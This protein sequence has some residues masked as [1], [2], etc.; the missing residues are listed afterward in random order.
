MTTRRAPVTNTNTVSAGVNSVRSTGV[1]RLIARVAPWIA[2][3]GLGAA[4]VRTIEIPFPRSEGKA[5]W[6]LTAILYRPEGPGPYPLAVINHG[7]AFTVEDR[8]RPTQAFVEQSRWFVDRGFVVVVPSRRGYGSSDGTYAEGYGRCEDA[9]YRLAGLETAR[10]IW[11]VIDFMSKQ[12]FVDGSRVVV[13]GHSAG[14]FGSLA[15]ASLNPPGVVGVI[16]FAGGR[17]SIGSD[18]VC[19]PEH[20]RAAFSE[21]GRSSK[22]PSLWLYSTN[23]GYFGPSLARAW[24]EAYVAAGGRAQF[25][26]LPPTGVAAHQVFADPESVELS[27]QGRDG[28]QLFA[29]PGSLS[30][31]TG[32]VGRFLSE[33]GFAP[34]SGN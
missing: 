27:P 32:A 13:V 28:H 6:H 31:W 5:Q 4:C 16:N 21:L 24:Y 23:D 29:D 30:L 3:A 25:V 8:R 17:G 2:I 26:E 7:S 33:L 10:D 14:G 20:L 34:R 1:L 22:I 15:L 9:N 11:A 18:R 12:A 19:A